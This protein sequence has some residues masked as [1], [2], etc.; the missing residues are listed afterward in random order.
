[1]GGYVDVRRILDC[2]AG[3]DTIT[4]QVRVDRSPYSVAG[5]GDDPGV[6]AVVGHRHPIHGQPQSI[7]QGA[8]T[9]VAQRYDASPVIHEI[10]LEMRHQHFGPRS[11]DRF[12]CFRLVS[13]DLDP[14]PP[15]S[16]DKGAA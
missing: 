8:R 16:S 1:T 14:P 2:D 4:K 5:A 12:L 9:E 13:R 3:G 15:A 7:S 11:L 6:D 10:Y